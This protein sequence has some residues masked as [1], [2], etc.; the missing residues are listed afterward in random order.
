MAPEKDSTTDLAAA[1]SE[2]TTSTT[3]STSQGRLQK[4]SASP[5]PDLRCAVCNK[6]GATLC[7]TH[8]RRKTSSVLLRGAL[9]SKACLASR[10]RQHI[11]KVERLGG[12]LSYSDILGPNESGSFVPITTNLEHKFH[13]DHTVTMYH[14]SNFFWDGRSLTNL[15][16]FK[17]TQDEHK[18][19]WRGPIAVFSQHGIPNTSGHRD[20]TLADLRVFQNLLVNY[21]EGLGNALQYGGLRMVEQW[22]PALWERMMLRF[23]PKDAKLVKGVKISCL[24]DIRVLRKEQYTSTGVLINHPIFFNEDEG[25]DL[26][27]PPASTQISAHMNLPLLVRRCALDPAW[28]GRYT[29]ARDFAKA[30]DSTNEP[31]ALL[32]TVADVGSKFWVG[33]KE[34]EDAD[35][36]CVSGSVIVVRQDKKDLSVEQVRTMA[37]YIKKHIKPAIEKQVVRESQLDKE[38]IR[39]GRE[40]IIDEYMAIKGVRKHCNVW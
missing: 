1:L 16:I 14:R 39:E 12:Q 37:D 18:F 9:S 7:N 32:T 30:L 10:E 8:G 38:Q 2:I 36:M 4:Q 33:N 26:N 29:N 13:L 23:M 19:D 20:A 28:K 31:A 5:G 17:F 21:G 11:E 35:N 22:D 24:G 27:E 34:D 25:E 15:A 3:Q 6:T 40:R